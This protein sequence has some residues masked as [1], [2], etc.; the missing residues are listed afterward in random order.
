M[1]SRRKAALRRR[2]TETDT[3]GAAAAAPPSRQSRGVVTRI[4]PEGLKALRQ[5]ALDRDITLQALAVEAF[6]DVLEKHGRR[7]AV[8]NPLLD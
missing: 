2:E 6:N 5:L 7:P 4:N 1:A 8:R 3:P